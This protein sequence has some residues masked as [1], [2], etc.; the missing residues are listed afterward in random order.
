[1]LLSLLPATP[2]QALH[3]LSLL[4]KQ[5]SIQSLS[6]PPLKKVE[7]TLQSWL[8]PFAESDGLFSLSSGV[9]APAE[10]KHDLIHAHEKG[11]EAMVS[12]FRNGLL[13][14]KINFYFTLHAMS[15]KTFSSL[16]KSTPVA[17][18]ER[19]AVFRADRNLFA[20][21]AVVAQTRNLN[22]RQVLS[23]ELGPVPFS[24]ASPDGGLVKTAKSKLLP[25]L[26]GSILA[27]EDLP[28]SDS[29]LD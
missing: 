15:L 5:S 25:L 8:N 24:I 14:S 21:L 18:G 16:S 6:L 3:F 4:T 9:L 17:T 2:W 10:V 22:M 13:T 26:E 19:H 23:Y 12:F 11:R 1:M 27:A 20:R 29:N 7:E 28:H